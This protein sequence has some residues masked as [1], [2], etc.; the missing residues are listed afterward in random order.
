[1]YNILS[2][3]KRSLPEI[4]QDDDSSTESIGTKF[5][6]KSNKQNNK[7]INIST[8]HGPFYEDMD[9]EENECEDDIESEKEDEVGLK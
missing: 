4:S 9:S 8:S 1:M 7:P 3:Y 6:I 5:T 2:D